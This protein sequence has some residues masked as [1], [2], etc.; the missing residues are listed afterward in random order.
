MSDLCDLLP[1]IGHS[2]GISKATPAQA[3]TALHRAE[4]SKATPA[5]ASTAL[6]RAEYSNALFVPE[7]E[8]LPIQQGEVVVQH[9]FHTVLFLS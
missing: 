2:T 6:H 5:Q 9:I 4:Y 7:Q 1:I 8:S 3:S